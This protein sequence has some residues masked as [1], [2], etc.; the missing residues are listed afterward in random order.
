MSEKRLNRLEATREKMYKSALEKGVLS[1]DTIK[2]SEELDQLL[3]DFQYIDADE[4]K[5][6]IE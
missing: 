6:K 1:Y 5:N 2:L 4:E 3:N